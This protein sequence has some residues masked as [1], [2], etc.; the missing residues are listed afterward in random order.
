MCVFFYVERYV[1]IHINLFTFVKNIGLKRRYKILLNYIIGPVLFLV[2]SFSIY[3]KIKAQENL[4]ETW[5]VLK[6]SLY[7][8]WPLLLLMIA[9]MI[10][11]WTFEAKK[12]QI[13]ISPVQRVSLFKGFK[14][15]LSGLSFGLFIPN[16]MGEYL[17][18]MLYLNEGNRL[19]SI[20]VSFMGSLSQLLITLI[21]GVLGLYYLMFVKD[22]NVAGATG[23]SFIW[24]KAL[25]YAVFIAIAFF[26]FLYFKIGWVSGFFQNIPF[27][28][29]HRFLIEALKTFD[30]PTLFKVLF[31]SL[32]R[33]SVFVLQYLLMFY[34]FKVE[35]ALASAIS[36]ICVMFLLIAIVP[37]IPIAELGVRGEISLII[38]G[39]LSTNTIGILSA[40]VLIWLI[41]LIAPAMI[42]SLFVLSV[43]VFKKNGS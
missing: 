41:N 21:T 14:A 27:V 20:A 26:L 35:I 12:W 13:L 32:L 9:L 39:M 43:K 29:K 28:Y 15:V 4:P 22:I 37:T 31:V 2:L 36:S 40:T 5:N 34:L 7:E 3:K 19:K 24:F 30:T 6:E 23:L 33:F 10:V 18:R 17:G 25:L 16:G 11:N 38:F 42:G 8:Q 1:I